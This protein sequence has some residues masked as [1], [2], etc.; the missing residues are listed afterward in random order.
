MAFMKH[1][2]TVTKCNKESPV[3]LIL[4]NHVSHLSNGL[5]DYCRDKGVVMLTLP[6]HCSQKLQPL[7]RSVFGP[8]KKYI[9]T[10][11]DDWITNH[12]GKVMT[13][14]DIPSIIKKA[15]PAAATCKN[16]Y[17]GFKACGTVP[18]DRS[19]FSDSNFFPAYVTDRPNQENGITDIVASPGSV[20]ISTA[21]A[22][23]HEV[24]S[25]SSSN[26]AELVSA[27][28]TSNLATNDV[29]LTSTDR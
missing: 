4:D 28:K 22:L 2:V 23:T 11:C 27:L 1:F 19:I 20:D 21:L 6:P 5:I 13:I 3:L 12:P 8:L 15:L 26:N 9:N 16:I 25:S 18:Y 17:S 14:Y 24:A 10:T 29:R 7:D